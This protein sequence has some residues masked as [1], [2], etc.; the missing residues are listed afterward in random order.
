MK[1]FTLLLASFLFIGTGA[2]AQTIPNGDMETWIPVAG[3]DS[4]AGFTS[5]N[6]FFIPSVNVTKDTDAHGGSFAAK[7]VGIAWLSIIPV[8]GGIGTNAKVNLTTFTLSGGYPYTQ[9]P[10]AFTGWFKYAPV[11]ND[12]C[13]MLALFT[14]WN[15]TARD[16]IGVAQY[17]G[18]STGGSY[19]QFY[20]NVQYFSSADPDTAFVLALTSSAFLTAQIGSELYIDDLNFTFNVGVEETGYDAAVISAYPNP[21]SDRL[22][23][24]LN[25]QH[26]VASL[27]VF[28]VLGNLVKQV[29]VQSENISL[30]VNDLTN[31]MYFYQLKDNVMKTLH[32]GKFSVQH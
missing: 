23:I 6:L 22:Y 13:V 28:D 32:S 30:P 15:G 7:M 18:K 17:F 8:P 9:R 25:N 27:L 24:Q 20:S 3:Y 12:S 16:T 19:Q 29:K 21:A 1:R 4:I 14:K 11:N 2:F 10:N 26:Q 31:G 5:T